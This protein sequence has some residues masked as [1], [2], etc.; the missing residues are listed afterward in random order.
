MQLLSFAAHQIGI[1]GQRV[2]AHA[3]AAAPA[4]PVTGLRRGSTHAPVPPY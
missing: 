3:V 1:F 4:N 2:P